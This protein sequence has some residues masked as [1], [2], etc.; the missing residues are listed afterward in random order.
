MRFVSAIAVL[1]VVFVALSAAFAVPIAE[2]EDIT[3]LCRG[4]KVLVWFH[5][6]PVPEVGQQPNNREGKKKTA[7]AVQAA[8]TKAGVTIVKQVVADAQPELR[9][10]LYQTLLLACGDQDPAE[11][12]K[13]VPHRVT[14][15]VFRDGKYV[16]GLPLEAEGRCKGFVPAPHGYFLWGLGDKRGRDQARLKGLKGI[17]VEDFSYRGPPG[18]GAGGESGRVRIFPEGDM[19]LLEMFLLTQ[20]EFE[21]VEPGK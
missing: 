11:A 13:D 9:D 10:H 1:V 18:G 12:L 14:G 5:A 17:R 7:D 20:A 4:Q 16:R 19:T 15:I 2:K 21:L 8:L 3:A 6:Y